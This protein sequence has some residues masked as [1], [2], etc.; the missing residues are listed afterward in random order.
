VQAY[1]DALPHA[2]QHYRQKIVAK[3]EEITSKVALYLDALESQPAA[4]C[5]KTVVALRSS[6]IRREGLKC[7]II[8]GNAAGRYK[9]ATSGD[10][11]QIP[12]LEPILDCPTRWSSTSNMILRFRLLY[13]V[14]DF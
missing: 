4:A 10:P 5:R 7:T 14:S 1:L 9:T 11:V 6:G 13:M 12:L 2:A 3:G 8:E